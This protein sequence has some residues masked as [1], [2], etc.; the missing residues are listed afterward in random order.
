[1]VFD[2]VIPNLMYQPRF[3]VGSY[4][5]DFQA[6]LKPVVASCRVAT[7]TFHVYYTLMNTSRLVACFQHEIPMGLNF[8][9]FAPGLCGLKSA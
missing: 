1:M 7:K 2:E 9:T 4:T 5:S 6:S 3:H 8:M